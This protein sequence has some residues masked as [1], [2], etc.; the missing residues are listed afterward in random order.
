MKKYI[1]SFLLLIGLSACSNNQLGYNVITNYKTT[2]SSSMTSSQTTVPVSTLLT[3]DGHT[4]TTA[5]VGGQAFL[6]IEPGGT[7]EEIVL[8]TVV[9]VSSFT[10]CTRGLA[11]YGTST[12]SI[13]TNAHAHQSG[14]TVIMS[15]VNYSVKQFVDKDSNETVGG[16][17]NFTGNT[18][19]QG[20]LGVNSLTTFKYLPVATSAIATLSTQLVNKATLDA[21]VVASSYWARTGSDIYY[22]AGKVGIGTSSPAY[23]L[24]V[25]GAGDVGRFISNNA[26]AQL[27]FTT[28]GNILYLGSHNG[29]FLVNA[30]EGLGGTPKFTIKADGKVGIGTINPAYIFQTHVASNQNLAIQSAGGI[31]GILSVNDAANT[32]QPLEIDGSTLSLN[33]ATN[34]NIITGSGSLTAGSFIGPITYIVA[35]NNLKYS[36]D[37]ERAGD[38]GSF[39]P[40]L[41]KSIQINRTGTIRVKFDVDFRSFSS[42]TTLVKNNRYTNLYAAYGNG[43]ASL[44]YVSG[45]SSGY[46]TYTTDISVSAGDTIQLYTLGDGTHYC[47]VKNFR[48]YYDLTNWTVDGAVLT[49]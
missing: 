21:S 38:T 7:S 46:N 10:S 33:T 12:L 44:F 41:T 23:I 42:F 29:D 2:L 9:S 22:S 36:A 19:V 4:I 49:D 31:P 5:D 18:L 3:H 32:Y 24:D 16:N 45:N 43:M 40:V 13:P 15:N 48:I 47:N 8:C 35:S 17:K 28:P 25:Y 34:G 6:T 1:F 27:R 20:T 11:Y 37:T 39:T 30:N 14:V 26:Y